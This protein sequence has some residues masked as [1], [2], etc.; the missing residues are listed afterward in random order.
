MHF[1][2]FDDQNREYVITNPKLLGHGSITL[3]MK[4]FSR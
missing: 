2:H 1:G 4:T 3:A